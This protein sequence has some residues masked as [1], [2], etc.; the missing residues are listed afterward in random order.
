[1]NEQFEVGKDFGWNFSSTKCIPFK[2]E[3]GRE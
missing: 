3:A 2:M 1:M